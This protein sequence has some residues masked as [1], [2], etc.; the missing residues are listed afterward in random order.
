MIILKKENLKKC[1]LLNI[2][3]FKINNKNNKTMNLEKKKKLLYIE[4]HYQNLLNLC[5]KYKEFH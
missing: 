1:L 2:Y 3:L 5:L 4:E